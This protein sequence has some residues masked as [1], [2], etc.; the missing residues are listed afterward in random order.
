MLVSAALVLG[1]CGLPRCTSLA[2]TGSWSGETFVPS[3]CPMPDGKRPLASAQRPQWPIILQW[4]RI[5]NRPPVPEQVSPACYYGVPTND[6]TLELLA[7][8]WYLRLSPSPSLTRSLTRSLT[9]TL[10]LTLNPH[11][12]LLCRRLKLVG[13]VP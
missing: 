13:D 10:T 4:V 6:E 2:T 7:G 8:S 3:V 9:L 5:P 1:Q 12:V 11:Q